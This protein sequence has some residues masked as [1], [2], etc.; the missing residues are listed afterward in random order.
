MNRQPLRL[1]RH[2]G[3]LE[4]MTVMDERAAQAIPVDMEAP[5]TLTAVGRAIWRAAL[6]TLHGSDKLELSIIPT[7]FSYCKAFEE[8]SAA[9]AALNAEMASR[10][11]PNHTRLDEGAAQCRAAIDRLALLERHLGVIPGS[12]NMATFGR[13]R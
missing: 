12:L 9:E 4:S 2:V 8:W 6:I 5:E 7:L 10:G 13:R 1:V 11:P 3:I